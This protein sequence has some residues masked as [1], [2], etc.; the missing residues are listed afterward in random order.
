[1]RCLHGTKTTFFLKKDIER[2]EQGPVTLKTILGPGNILKAAPGSEKLVF[3][4]GRHW[5]LF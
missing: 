1:M 3:L 2:L 5:S 4:L